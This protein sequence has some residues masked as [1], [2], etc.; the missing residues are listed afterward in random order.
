[1]LKTSSKEH[2]GLLLHRKAS[3]QTLFCNSRGKEVLGAIKVCGK[4]MWI[5]LRIRPRFALLAQLGC[6]NSSAIANK[7]HKTATIRKSQ[8]QKSKGTRK[9]LFFRKFLRPGTADCYAEDE[10]NETRRDVSATPSLFKL[11]IARINLGFPWGALVKFPPWFAVVGPPPRNASSHAG[12][13]LEQHPSGRHYSCMVEIKFFTREWF[14]LGILGAIAWISDRQS[15]CAAICH[16][17][18]SPAGSS[19]TKCKYG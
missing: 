11:N 5:L 4:T 12:E 6:R 13:R 7:S 2:L 19:F 16:A 3:V 8:C 17:R 9:Y 10:R 14:S 15:Q 1:M 18:E